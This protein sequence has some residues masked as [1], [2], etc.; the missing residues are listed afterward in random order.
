MDL[1]QSQR[2]PEERAAILLAGLAD[3]S[4]GERI[5]FLIARIAIARHKTEAFCRADMLTADDYA[6][7]DKAAAKLALWLG[8]NL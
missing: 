4:P 1:P 3:K 5:D 6:D 2:T 7:D 8:R